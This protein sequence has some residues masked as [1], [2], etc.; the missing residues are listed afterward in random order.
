[1]VSVSVLLGILSVFL[2]IHWLHWAFSVVRGLSLVVASGGSSGCRTQ[3]SPCGG[4][5]GCGAQALSR[6]AL[7]VAA[8][9]LGSCGSLAVEHGLGG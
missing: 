7:A 3:S 6:Q 4:S 8:G 9:R 5:S 1:M 2:F